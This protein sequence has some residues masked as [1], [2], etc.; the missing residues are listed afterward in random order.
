[1]WELKGELSKIGPAGTRL[2]AICANSP[3]PGQRQVAIFRPGAQP[4]RSVR[5][6]GLLK[7]GAGAFQKAYGE[8]FFGYQ[9]ICTAHPECD[10][11]IRQLVSSREG[12]TGTARSWRTV[13]A[14]RRRH[15]GSTRLVR[16]KDTITIQEYQQSSEDKYTKVRVPREGLLRRF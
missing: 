3:M 9:I 10:E 16:A 1:M 5:R 6:R 2:T 15:R 11:S 4:N 13:R 8:Q 7:T 14:S 12:Q